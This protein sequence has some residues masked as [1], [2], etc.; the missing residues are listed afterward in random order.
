MPQPNMDLRT[1]KVCGKK[2]VLDDID[3]DGDIDILAGNLGLNT[4]Y[5]ASQ[6]EP[7]TLTYG[8]FD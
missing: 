4:Q 8:D 1:L 5:R 6:K 2:I 3:N 7:M